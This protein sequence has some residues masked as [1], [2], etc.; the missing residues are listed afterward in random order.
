MLAHRV[1]FRVRRQGEAATAPTGGTGLLA[2][3]LA[4]TLCTAVPAWANGSTERVSVGP[5][6]AQGDGGSIL[7]SISANGRFVAFIATADNLVPG[8]HNAQWDVFV[9]D[10][11]TGS[12]R[13]IS[14][15]RGGVQGNGDTLTQTSPAI[16]AG[17]RFV[18]FAS[19]ASNLVAGDTNGSADIFVRDRA[20]GTTERV[21]LR[22][23]GGQAHGDSDYPAISAD[24]R[25]VVF[26][27]LA[28]D[29]VPGDTNGTY[30]VF[31]RDRKLGTTRRLSTGPGDIQG[32]DYSRGPAISANGRFVSFYS[33]ATNLVPGETNQTQNVF[34]RDRQTGTTEY[35]SVG[36]GGIQGGPFNSTLSAISADGRYVAFDSDA[37]N[38]V[39]GD[40]N[41]RYDVFIRD[42]KAATTHRLSRA[43]GGAQ[44]NAQSFAPTISADGRFVAFASEATN[45]VPGD[46]NGAPDVFIRDRRTD[47]TRRLSIGPG[48]IQ[49][50]EYSFNPA[51]SADG[52]FVAFWSTA[53]NLVSNDTNGVADVFV[54]ILA[55]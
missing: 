24:G 35:V 48:G 41:G 4:L 3:A 30:D 33:R 47:T 2:S 53:S 13:L 21:S 36:P 27:S 51:I 9:R 5:S 34:I 11:K 39:P 28:A 40:T 29:L 25:F 43:S 19:Y 26:E 18:A 49:G 55:P 7:P 52:R 42:R 54:H 10:R 50:N 8:D 1:R 17:G 14:R 38:L 12:T 6:G 37:A 20:T 45:L 44:G 31:I 46:N 22:S 16:S 15:G 32:D 23:G